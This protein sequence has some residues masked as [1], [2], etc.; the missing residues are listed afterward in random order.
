VQEQL[1]ALQSAVIG[2]PSPIHPGAP[3][4]QGPLESSAAG[5]RR[6]HGRCRHGAEFEGAWRLER[7]LLWSLAA[8][9]FGL[10]FVWLC[11]EVLTSWEVELKVPSDGGF[12][13][14]ESVSVVWWVRGLLW[15]V[16]EKFNHDRIREL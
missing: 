16:E 5:G 2:R 10:S 1:D 8:V 11:A 9:Y 14:G 12:W 4:H 6:G 13:I 3:L 7:A 15:V